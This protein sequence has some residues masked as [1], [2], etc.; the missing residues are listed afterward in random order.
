MNKKDK[1]FWAAAL[2]L[3]GMSANYH[4]SFIPHDHWVSSAV[5][6]ADTLLKNLADKP[7]ESKKAAK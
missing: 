5:W 3:G 4:H 2:I 6:L 1:R 7:G